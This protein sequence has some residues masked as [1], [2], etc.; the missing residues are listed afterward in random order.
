MKE[1]FIKYN[2][3]KLET[4]I[5]IDGKGLEDNNE[6][7]EK[8]VP[9]SRLQEWLEDLP[10]ILFRECN[11]TDFHILF[12]GTL[13]DYEDLVD[14]FTLVCKNTDYTVQLERKS[15]EEIDDKDK[16]I[17]EVY[18]EILETS[19]FPEL[20][21]EEIQNA[22]RLAKSSD[23]EV[24]VVATMSA[25]KSTLINAMLGTKLMPSKQEAC[26]AIITRI[27]DTDNKTWQA[28]VYDKYGNQIETHE[29][30]TYQTMERLN[31]DEKTA[32]IKVNGNIPF[33][34]SENVSLVLID[35]PGP[36]NARDS[37]HKEVQR[38]FLNKSSKSLVLYVMEPTFGNDANN[39]LLESIAESMSV[40]GKQSKD[41]FIFVV[42]KMDGRK[43]EDGD[44]K[45]TLESVCEYL[46]NHKIENPNLFLIT[47]LTALNIRLIKN[48]IAVDEDTKDDTDCNV[49]KLNRNKNM[50]FENYASSLPNSIRRDIDSQLKEAQQNSD[51]QGAALIHTGVI[52]VEAAIRQY[53]EKYA[54]TAKIKNIV[55]TFIHKLDATGS[56]E[57]V[58]KEIAKNR[59]KRDEVV[60][61]LDLILQKASSIALAEQFEDKVIE[62][63]LQINDVSRD[64]IKEIRVDFQK[65]I[66]KE[67]DKYNGK[68]LDYNEAEAV[69]RDLE[70]FVKDQELVFCKKLNT[71][72]DENLVDTCKKLIEEYKSKLTS[73][74]EEFDGGLSG[75]EI[76]PLSFIGGNVIFADDFSIN[77]YARTKKVEDGEEWIKNTDKKWYKPWTWFQESGYY[78]KKYKDVEYIPADEV[79]Q[80][81]FRPMQKS[82]LE[83]SANAKK[84]VLKES[85]R[86][87]YKFQM[88]FGRLDKLLKE[89][90]IELKTLAMDK[91]NAE[92]H[93]L[94]SEQNLRW[95][96]NM[97]RKVESILEI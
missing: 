4:E 42:N 87:A 3:Y 31:A 35:T 68:Q 18:K 12:H 57:E 70:L 95:L 29:E 52:S 15:A 27:K 32:E 21:D 86:I 39:T 62:V 49:K 66:T 24:C 60:K 36:D 28:K 1:I 16:L 38:D 14:V 73:L 11:D 23:F 44:T 22:F 54:K 85:I 56:F 65:C 46:K 26:T 93:L 47:A 43:K 63:V 92:E 74:T 79:A 10:S 34:T 59:D 33:V 50:H 6:L 53:V 83:N 72:V 91:E 58:K 41:R 64:A 51:A 2:P 61:Q 80:D 7:A 45:D 8:A 55:D 76:N 40:G 69:V 25:G 30:L 82:I 5:T 71:L 78:R 88:E 90:V 17:D 19:P 13:P 67:S 75:I 81:F 94:R 48:G 96:E 97:K 89:K 77:T 84:H 37:L 9:G 20:Q